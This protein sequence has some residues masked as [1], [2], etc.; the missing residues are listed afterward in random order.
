[1]PELMKYT[2]V[3]I[4]NEEDCQM[5][6][7]IKAEADVHSGKL[8]HERLQQPDRHRSEGL[9]ESEADRRHVARIEERFA[10]RLV[11]LPE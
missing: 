8:E 3:C 5:A 10:Q 6:L 2:D 9:P 7:G 11:R 4:A 1:M